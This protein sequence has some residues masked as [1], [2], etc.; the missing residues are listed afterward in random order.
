MKKHS[1]DSLFA[2][3]LKEAEIKPRQEAW[4]KLQSRMQHK[5]KHRIGGWWQQGPWL[6]A[7]GVCLLLVTGW[8]VW[9]SSASNDTELAQHSAKTYV[10]KR[11]AEKAPTQKPKVIPAPKTLIEE[12][13]TEQIAVVEN[14]P[15]VTEKPVYKN[16]GNSASGLKQ[17]VATPQSMIAKINEGPKTE[18]QSAVNP[19][20]KESLP[21]SIDR[22]TRSVAQVTGISSTKTVVLQLPEIKETQVVS[23]A[24]E[25]ELKSEE[26][27]ADAD[28]FDNNLLN[29][30]R[31][32][33]RMAKVWKQ[34]KNAKN[35]ERV[36]WDEV[37]FNPN[38]MLAKAT[39]KEKER[40]N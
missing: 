7:A 4:D 13:A 35:G 30:P 31:T 21:T 11:K 22:E 2:Q 20:I 39:G 25:L 29:K 19:S 5:K 24:K 36:D 16:T 18:D 28:D 26:N 15:K 10:A 33:T 6:A 12:Q 17:P 27:A 23:N 1:I 9:R 32:S 40:T 3:K 34:L 8:L 38:K 14:K 37:G